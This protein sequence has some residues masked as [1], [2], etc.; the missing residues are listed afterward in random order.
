MAKGYVIK[1]ATGQKEEAEIWIYEE[2]GDGWF[3]G[4]SAKGFADDVKAL[5]AVKRIK[6][7]INSPGGNVFDGTAIYNILKQHS[8]QVAVHIDGLAASIASV[9]AMAG[10]EIIM[11]ENALMMI[12]N[13][14]AMAVGN[15]EELRRQ[16]EMLDKVNEAIR[17]TYIR[18]TGRED[19]EIA[20]W[21]DEETWMTAKEA[22]ERGFIDSTSPAQEVA[23]CFDLSKFN[24]KH[25]P[26]AAV[27][28]SGHSTRVKLAKM[29]ILSRRIRSASARK[30]GSSVSSKVTRAMASSQS[31]PGDAPSVTMR[32]S[33]SLANARPAS[34]LLKG[35]VSWARRKARSSGLTSRSSTTGAEKPRR[36]DG[37]GR[38]A[39][40]KRKDC[41]ASVSSR[42]VVGSTSSPFGL[43]RPSAMGITFAPLSGW[44]GVGGFSCSKVRV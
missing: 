25:A 34:H 16:A 31:G 23:A 17:A 5:G 12:H 22:Q 19:K 39:A 10:D 37:T 6:L 32:A 9:I 40:G 13:A 21:M 26:A 29:N 28:T 14:W 4:I 2:I 30:A 1:A 38:V 36:I 42:T 24:F 20:R 35:S 3:G 41:L 44:P 15:A 33:R 7:R 8:A 18:R 27:P 11:A 43:R